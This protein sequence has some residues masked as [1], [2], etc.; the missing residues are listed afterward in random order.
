ML[1]TILSAF[2]VAE[3]RKKLAFTALLLALYRSAR[4]SRCRGSTSQAVKTSRTQF[5][6]VEHP[7]PPEHVPRRRAV[8]D[9]AVRARDHAVHHGVD[10]PA[11]ADGRRARRWRSSPRRARS[12]RRASRSTRATSPSASP[13]PSRSATSSSSS[14]LRADRRRS[15]SSTNFDAAARLPDRHLADRRLRAADVDGRAHHPARHRQRDLADDLRLDR[16][17]P[18]AAACRPGGRAPTPGLQGHDA[19]PRARR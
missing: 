10:H 12:G 4:T 17:A 5:G 6:G 18:A 8:A 15:R 14:S 9:R 2:T 7:Q 13:S 19:V 16:L 3:I 11:A 1:T